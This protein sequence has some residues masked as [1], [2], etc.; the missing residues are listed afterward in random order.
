[1]R[2]SPWLAGL[3]TLL[4]VLAACSTPAA[5]PTPADVPSAAASASTSPQASS[6][7]EPSAEATPSPTP[8]ASDESPIATLYTVRRGDTL[9]SI[10]KTYGVSMDRLANSNNLDSDDT[11]SVGQKLSIPGTAKLAVDW[12]RVYQ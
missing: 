9:W 3:L 4:V 10:A 1:M 6:S 2:R 7:G 5:S 8:T 12:V 11:L